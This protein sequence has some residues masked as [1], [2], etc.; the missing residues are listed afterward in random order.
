MNGSDRPLTGGTHGKL[1]CVSSNSV[2]WPRQ[3]FSSRDSTDIPT[4]GYL[5]S[6]LT[7]YVIAALEGRDVAVIDVP[8][9]F[10]QTDLDE[11]IHVRFTG[12]VYL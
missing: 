6:S 8:G 7:L 3:R 10:M 12:A 1:C 11:L 4:D 5:D 2:R 9:A